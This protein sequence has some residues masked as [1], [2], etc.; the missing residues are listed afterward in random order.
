MS[1]SNSSVNSSSFTLKG[2]AELLLETG[3]LKAELLS[4]IEEF[5]ISLFIERTIEDYYSP[6]NN[7]E[8]ANKKYL[9]NKIL[10]L[11]LNANTYTLFS[12][13]SNYLDQIEGESAKKFIN[14]PDCLG[15]VL[16]YYM[17]ADCQ[18]IESLDWLRKN[19]SEVKVVDIVDKAYDEM[20]GG[21]SSYGIIMETSSNKRVAP[22][23]DNVYYNKSGY[24]ST[25]ATVNDIVWMLYQQ[26]TLNPNFSKMP[27][28]WQFETIKGL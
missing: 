12:F 6:I 20:I 24:N 9:K 25:L 28:D 18:A 7:F 26:Y 1:S 2:D 13:A 4:K 15:R 27:L 19:H 5:K 14:R 22:A 11:P 23:C 17:K 21:M 16:D 10:D 3:T 8:E